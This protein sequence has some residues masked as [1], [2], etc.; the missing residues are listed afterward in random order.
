MIVIKCYGVDPYAIGD[1]S[2]QYSHIIRERLNTEEEILFISPDEYIYNNGVEQTSWQAY[3]EVVID[4]KYE[5]LQA[6]LSQLILEALEYVAIHKLIKFNYFSA[7]H[8]VESIDRERPR[9]I[10]TPV[11]EFDEDIDIE[12]EE[13]LLSKAFIGNA[14]DDVEEDDLENSAYNRYGNVEEGNE[15]HHHH[16]NHHHHHENDDDHLH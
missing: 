9:F 3:I 5:H 14:F 16:H 15:E 2:H 7:S 1:V 10:D 8:V 11:S 13:D 6:E 4:Q 12:G